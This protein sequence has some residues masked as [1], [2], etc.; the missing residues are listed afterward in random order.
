MTSIPPII[1]KYLY[2]VDGTHWLVGVSYRKSSES[3]R[4][5]T[6]SRVSYTAWATYP[7]GGEG[8]EGNTGVLVGLGVGLAVGLAVGTEALPVLL[9]VVGVAAVVVLLVVVVIM[10]LD[11]LV[12]GVE[13]GSMPSS[14]LQ[15]VGLALH[16]Q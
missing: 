16:G 15:R 4:S 10:V 3:M 13:T 1:P 14:Q 8:G 2:T 9:V 6:C 7:V 11:V 12:T 5:L